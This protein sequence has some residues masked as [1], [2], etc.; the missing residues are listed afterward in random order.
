MASWQSLWSNYLGRINNL[1]YTPMNLKI[2]S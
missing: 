1:V 2:V